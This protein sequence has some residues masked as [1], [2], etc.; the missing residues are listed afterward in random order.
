MLDTVTT[1]RPL[2]RWHPVDPP[3]LVP[4]R[5]Y[6]EGES[7]RQLVVRS[8]VTT[9]RDPELGDAITVTDVETWAA[10]ANAAHP[11]V[12]VDYPSACERHVAPPKISQLEAELQGHFD[13]AM[14]PEAKPAER[15]R[16]ILVARREAGSFLDTSIPS[17]DD[18]AGEVALPWVR[19]VD[20]PGAD[21]PLPAID[22]L[23]R[24]D[25]LAPG[26]YVVHDTDQT[27]L[28]YLP[29]PMVRG[30]SMVF[31]DAGRDRPLRPPI[32]IEGTTAD[33]P[34]LD[35]WPEVETYRI[36][37]GGGRPLAAKVGARTIAMSL[38]PAD[39]LRVRLSSSIERDKLDQFGFWRSLPEEVREQPLLREAA[40]D[41]WLWALSPAE[42]LVF[43]HAVPKPLE[44]PRVLTL[45]PV[46]AD[47]DTG[48]LLSGVVDVHGPSTE[49]VDIEA[50]WTQQEDDVAQPGPD[51]ADPPARH[52]VACT[53]PVLD[54]EDLAVLG[55][56]DTTI[57]VPGVGKLRIH[58]ARHEFG[59][60]RHRVVEYRCRAAT[61]FREYFHPALLADPDDRSV[62]GPVRRVSIPN[63]AR[64]PKPA[65]RQ[66]LPMFRWE[67]ETEPEQ[68]FGLRRRRR[69][70]V[71]IYLDRPWYSSGDGELLGVVLGDLGDEPDRTD[72][73][74]AWGADP[75]WHG[76]GPARRAI[77]VE[78]DQL[79]ASVGREL[80]AR[81]VRPVVQLPLV[82][83]AQNP[84]AG[85]L[86]YR[87]EY[88]ATRKLWFTDIAIDPGAAVWPFLRLVVTRYQP[89]SISGRHLSPLVR[90]D[91]VQ[92]PLE[93]AATLTRPDERTLRVVLSGAV[94]YRG[95]AD[96]DAIDAASPDGLQ[97]IRT[98]V[99]AQRRVQA[100]LERRSST[101]ATDLGWETLAE[102]P[103]AIEGFDTTSLTAAYVGQ[104]ELPEAGRGQE[105]RRR[106][107]VAR[108][109]R[110]D[111]VARRRSR[112]P[113]AADRS[114][115]AQV[116]TRRLPRPLH[117]VALG[118]RLS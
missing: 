13:A 19:L 45:R 62:L 58:R 97:A 65:V 24:G 111:R 105:A 67:E 66:V 31:P 81:P 76:R 110:G 71:R 33:Y 51:D 116:A 100:R 108:D 4:R 74:S 77:S 37:L 109:H 12:D 18:P 49:R 39:M 34:G 59:D 32:S 93:R 16:A 112:G 26:Q 99:G 23:R 38:P 82:D 22:T 92:I 104:L 88:D 90:C 63:S 72:A 75:V 6:T 118:R 40:A 41:G 2:L 5:A 1:L 42:D 78:L 55:L 83:L 96:L 43:V 54:F 35:D 61:R 94:G 14:S 9:T 107:K 44:A 36:V 64:P 17:L 52:A 102:V 91:Y 57:D 20:P 30:V 53:L 115:A 29:D 80:P 103:L 87:P 85:V 15:R 25:P 73:T 50:T 10:A 95:P 79:F 106:F 60:T 101:I 117:G 3:V 89:E 56:T 21:G 11:G 68:P 28:P 98:R 8:G 69:A 84:T 48:V 46:R 70:G 47:A 86:G 113:A 27:V 114:A 7:L